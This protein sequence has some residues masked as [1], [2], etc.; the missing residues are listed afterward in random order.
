MSA[1]TDL[2]A[3]RLPVAWRQPLA[4]FVLVLV[5]L[6]GLYWNTWAA[7]VG[8]WERSGTFAHCYLVAPISV[9]LAW[10]VR[11]ELFAMVPR[12]VPWL[13]APM[14]AVSLVWL[15]G[16]MA[17]VNALT[18]FAATALLVMAVPLNLGWQVTR[19]L[20][21]PLLF[22]FFMVPFGEFLL[23]WLMEWTADFTV[24]A[25]RLS[26]IPVYREGLQFVIPSGTWSVVE[27]CSGVRYLIAS[28]MVGSL[29]AYLNYTSTKRRL[30]FGLV[31]LLVPLVANWLRAY[32]IVML[33][34]LSGNKL[35]VGVDHLIYGWVFFGVIVG[36]MFWVGARW[37]EP[38]ANQDPSRL[39]RLAPA[40]APAASTWLAAVLG[41][42]ALAL[43]VAYGLHLDAQA[44][45]PRS[46]APLALAALPGTV[47][48]EEA[49]HYAPLA[50]NPTATAL[51]SYG[52]D[53]AVVHVHVAYY[54]QQRYGAKMTTSDNHLVKG[55]DKEW[56]Q[57]S[58]GVLVHDTDVGPV[59]FMRADLLGGSVGAVTNRLRMD[60]RQ[61]YWV[62]GQL[63]A[64]AHLATLYGL[65]AR[66]L[67]RGDDGA[68]ITVYTEG[69]DQ[70]QT[71]A[72]LSA[73]LKAYT[74]A[75]ERQ[76]VTYRALR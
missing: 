14:L 76:L 72:R 42:A 8:I 44:G 31:A 4:G 69:R 6:G 10:R 9:W 38:P 33:G 48:V 32:M 50:Q 16:D 15:M 1:V 28:A 3:P 5:A 62:D 59:S 2:P 57:V 73:F 21:F 23:P 64:S 60:V 53:G 11:A 12:P 61:T 29:F 26:G 58:P 67:G 55:V 47:A 18:Q 41:A 43:P 27:A 39:G 25:V 40:P 35:A 37:A 75:L 36:I 65:R 74:G 63:T 30:I 34:H 19:R 22:L 20:T 54:R 56:Q 45:E 66:L 52:F 70:A 49:P 51:R 68:L 24:A 71:A 46:A 17:S 7:M 13:A